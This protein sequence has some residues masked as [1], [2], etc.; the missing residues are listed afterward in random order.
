MDRWDSFVN[1]SLIIEVK[2]LLKQE[3]I[4]EAITL[5]N[6]LTLEEIENLNLTIVQEILNILNDIDIY[7]I[8]PFLPKFI[9]TTLDWLP[10]SHTLFINWLEIKIFQMEKLDD[11]NFPENAIEFLEVTS[12]CFEWEDPDQDM[13][14]SVVVTC[15]KMIQNLS[16]TLN[17]L[18]ILKTKY[19]VKITL[20][21]MMQV[22][23]ACA[24]RSSEAILF[25]C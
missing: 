12:V 23:R 11:D 18:Q 17:K 7:M 20:N 21:D 4:F 3:K 10:S 1:D 25:V 22:R 8:Y 24:S 19:G 9:E 2:R 15:S 5:Y 16:K 6:H 14:K 13:S